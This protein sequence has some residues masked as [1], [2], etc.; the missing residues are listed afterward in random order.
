MKGKYAVI[1][2][3]TKYNANEEY[4]SLDDE[5]MSLAQEQPG[6]LGYEALANQE[7]SIFISYWDSLESV[8]L[9]RDNAKHLY[10]KTRVGEWYERYLSQICFIES[11][12][13]WVKQS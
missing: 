3:S 4:K 5:L 11:S 6:F 10:A 7:K 1:F 2:A 12:H 8:N 13:E 9:W